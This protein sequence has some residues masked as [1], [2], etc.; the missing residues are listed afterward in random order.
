MFVE[1]APT[2][3]LKHIANMIFDIS[4]LKFWCPDPV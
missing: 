3:F 2:W 4:C 1:G